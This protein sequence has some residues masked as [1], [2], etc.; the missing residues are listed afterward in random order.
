MSL[1]PLEVAKKLNEACSLSEKLKEDVRKQLQP[2][3]DRGWNI[4][5][6]KEYKGQA[7][8]SLSCGVIY[9]T[10]TLGDNPEW[11]SRI[12]AGGKD[13]NYNNFNSSDEVLKFVDE[14]EMNL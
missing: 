6:I 8:K 4:T 10:Y 11:F 2:F 7:S 14:I 3:K 13:L 1:T 9:L 12:D 5:S